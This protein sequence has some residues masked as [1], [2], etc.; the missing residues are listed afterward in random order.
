MELDWQYMLF[1]FFGG[2]GL[3]LFSIKYM[4]EGL[5]KSVD[6]RL[7]DL[8]NRFT[9]NP[10]IGV[11]VGIVITILLHS[12]TATTVL[13]VGLVG[14]SFLTLR[15]AIGVIMG[16]NIGT[17]L[18]SFIIGIQIDIYFYLMIA[19]GAFL[20]LFF[21]NNR[22]QHVGQVIFGFG[23][24]FLAIEMM[25]ESLKPLH[26][27]D[28]FLVMID[29]ISEN[30]ILGV[31]V[32]IILTI[33]VQ[34]S[35][36]T[37]GILQG[38][39]SEHLIPLVGAMP[40]L[41]GENIGTTFT[42]V[43]ASIGA[44][45]SAKRAAASHVLF[46]VIG[47]GIFLLLLTPFTMFIDWVAT[48]FHLNAMMQ[49]AFAHGSFNVISTLIFLPFIPVMVYIVTKLIPGKVQLIDYEQSH[50]DKSF[51]EASPSIALGQ[52]KEEVLKMGELAVHGL[53]ET[54]TYLQTGNDKHVPIIRK[55]EKTL[56]YLDQHITDYVVRISKESLTSA[57]SV[58]HHMLLNNVRDIERI[59]D[60]FENI[61]EL[62]EYKEKQQL[63]LTEGAEKDLVDM[64]TLTL[65]TV[66]L[67][68]D[69]LNTSSIED[70]KEVGEKESYI[71]EMENHLR[72][73]QVA[74]MNLGECT[75]AAG[76]VFTDIVSNLERIGDHA[77]N[78]ADGILGIRK[79]S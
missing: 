25:S 69:A 43:M 20:V 63:I 60:H 76:L 34:S 24:L 45:V 8:L 40:V 22:M 67:S 19:I 5:Q 35:S 3:F 39:Y 17:T 64:F 26:H 23:G 77:V 49:I 73:K 46:N 30:P 65:H 37:V 14:A 10:I 31:I 74:R 9:S 42:A 58:R 79:N 29:R 6:Q 53:Q 51:I 59:G 70:A 41:F 78:I 13:V 7:R 18:T 4:G 66:E 28:S 68:L 54:L 72:Q 71:D 32:G 48:I 56:D 27:L 47:T 50:L 55:I 57:D 16:A 15:Q 33:F 21:K 11:F 75:G 52:A 12:S 61:L 1:Q 38:M 44:S 36:A 2:L 62:L